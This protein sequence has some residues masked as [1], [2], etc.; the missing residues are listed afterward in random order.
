LAAA[1]ERAVVTYVSGV[2]FGP[3]EVALI[4]LV[5]LVFVIW[6]VVDAARLDTAAWEAAGQSKVIWILFM[7][8]GFV[9]CG[10]IGIFATVI[11]FASIRPQV[12]RAASPG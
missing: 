6:G 1:S 12:K 2:S 11:Y 5:P 8:V 7:A 9:A 3:V 4:V 10:L